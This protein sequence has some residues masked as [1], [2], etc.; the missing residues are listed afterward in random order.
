MTLTLVTPPT[1][2]VVELED[3][4]AYLRVT[5]DDE[6]SL[7]E[8]LEQAAVAH[9][10]G[11]SGVLGRA[12][13]PQTWQQEFCG[14]GN[15]RLA[16]PDASDIVVSGLDTEGGDVVATQADLRVDRGGQYVIAD[17]PSAERVFVQFDCGLSEAEIPA[18]QQ[19]VKLIVGHWFENRSAVSDGPMTEVPMAA[20]A[21]V[22]RLSRIH[23]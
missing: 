4:K 22:R 8:S 23:I 2:P 1:E 12:I 11:W 13:R 3:L 7:I 14:W 5:S 6:D 16:M 17:G 18:V 10:D 19:A 21:L 15:L 20:A 9:L